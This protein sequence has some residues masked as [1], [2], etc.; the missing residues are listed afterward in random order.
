MKAAGYTVVVLLVAGPVAA[1]V[2][3]WFPGSE[4][5]RELFAQA[6]AAVAGDSTTA[7]ASSSPATAD[8]KGQSS[9]SAQAGSDS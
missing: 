6:D 8:V 7:V 1:L 9:G 4:T 2:Y 3:A 5:D